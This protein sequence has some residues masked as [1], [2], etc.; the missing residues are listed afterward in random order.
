MAGQYIDTVEFIQMLKRENLVIVPR[1]EFEKAN[2]N[3]LTFGEKYC[4][5]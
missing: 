1:K 3:G 2:Y 5:C 4:R